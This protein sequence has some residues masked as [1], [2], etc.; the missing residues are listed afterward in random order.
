MELVSSVQSQMKAFLVGADIPVRN[1]PIRLL[2]I[3]MAIIIAERKANDRNS[4]NCSRTIAISF[5]RKEFVKE[6]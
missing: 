1:L 4:D 5:S 6:F 3:V 2:K